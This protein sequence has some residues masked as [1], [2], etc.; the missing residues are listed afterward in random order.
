MIA[1]VMLC[2]PTNI[3]KHDTMK[4]LRSKMVPA[5]RTAPGNS[6]AV[7]IMPKSKIANPG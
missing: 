6:T 1:N 7:P 3:A 5:I 2:R 4:V